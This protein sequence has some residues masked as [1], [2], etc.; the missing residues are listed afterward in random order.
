MGS[1]Q[2]LKGLT[3]LSVFVI[4]YLLR[5]MSCR[6]TAVTSRKDFAQ[7]DHNIAVKCHRKCLLLRLQHKYT[8]SYICRN[9]VNVVDKS[10]VF[11]LVILIINLLLTK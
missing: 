8:V 3:V 7:F 2:I 4:I 9:V 5:P 11:I 10:F 1:F 6:R